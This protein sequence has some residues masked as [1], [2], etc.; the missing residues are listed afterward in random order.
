MIE[1]EVIKQMEQSFHESLN[2]DNADTCLLL[3]GLKMHDRVGFDVE[4]NGYT[5][6]ETSA[7]MIAG[8]L[9][10]N[11]DVKKLV[12]KLT[13]PKLLGGISRA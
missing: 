6:P 1:K 13:R 12:K 10:N 8:F 7:R 4:T 2:R 11:P 9:I 3:T 5:N